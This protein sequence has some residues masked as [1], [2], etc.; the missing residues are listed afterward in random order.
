MHHSKQLDSLRFVAVFMVL[1]E[2]LAYS[3]GSHF[4]AG[5]FGVDLFFVIS[6]FLITKILLRTDGSFIQG[7]KNFLGRRLLR[8]LPLYYLLIL[9]LLLLGNT[10]VKAY[11]LYCISFTYNYA[12][13][14]FNLPTHAITHFWSLC[15]EEQFYLFWPFVVLPLRRYRKLLLIF[16]LLF[17]VF[18]YGQFFFKWIPPLVKYTWVGLIPQCYAIG[19]GA[20]G[21]ITFNEKKITTSF[22]TNRKMEWF[23]FLILLIFLLSHSPFKFIFIPLVSLFLVLKCYYFGFT[24]KLFNV[25]FS[26][27]KLA[28]LGTISYGIYLFHLPMNFYLNKYFFMDYILDYSPVLRNNGWLIKLPLYTILSILLAGLSYRFFESPLLNL[29]DRY[30]LYNKN[31]IES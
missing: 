12:I 31:V 23:M 17:V 1:I 8:I 10:Y 9:I 15:V 29:K 16:V 5:Y 2:H 25:F 7:Y 18:C 11:L 22:F 19:I 3:L 20:I 14:Y 13:V 6:G 30:F 4:S 27:K 28:Y 26:N 24:E 21:A